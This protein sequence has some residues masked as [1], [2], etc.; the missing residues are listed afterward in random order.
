[1]LPDIYKSTFA[2]YFEDE[3]FKGN[4]QA[5]LNIL[6]R[7]QKIFFIGNGGSN[8][9][10]SHMYEDFAKIGKFRS[11]AFSDPAL[12]TCFSND[13]GYE[14]AMAEWLKIY[15]EKGDTLVAISSSGNS[16]NILNAC[17]V[18]EEKEA[19]LIVLSGFDPKNSLNSRTSDSSFHIPVKNY[20]VVECYHQVILHALLDT[21]SEIR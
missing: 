9:I 15:L 20:G 13:Y 6:K 16:K 8:S 3:A 17:Q 11:F 21:Y 4:F 10:C 1:M 19:N 18:A 5:S 14:L 2:Q 12:I 7:T